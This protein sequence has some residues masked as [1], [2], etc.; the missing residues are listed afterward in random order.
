MSESTVGNGENFTVLSNEEDVE[1]IAPVLDVS[2]IKWLEIALSVN[3]GVLFVCVDKG[4]RVDACVE[5]ASKVLSS[6]A[7][8]PEV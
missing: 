7:V 6:T 8:E 4:E 2:L 5:D 1:C 3:A